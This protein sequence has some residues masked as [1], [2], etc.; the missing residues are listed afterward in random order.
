MK[1]NYTQV[2]RS[3]I[4]SGIV[5]HPAPLVRSISQ[6]QQPSRHIHT[7]TQKVFW[8]LRG[9]SFGAPIPVVI[10]PGFVVAFKFVFGAILSCRLSIRVAVMDSSTRAPEA[11]PEYEQ[12]SS[13]PP[14]LV[15]PLSAR[16]Q[17]IELSNSFCG[18]WF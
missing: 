1:G 14:S 15:I 3:S 7:F 8:V 13:L 16:A 4:E 18:R 10:Q 5:A 11:G 9:G 12:L 17:H 2:G 6:S